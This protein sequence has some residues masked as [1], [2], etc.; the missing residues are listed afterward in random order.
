MDDAENSPSQPSG[1][2]KVDEK[3]LHNLIFHLIHCVF[4]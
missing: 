2:K 1:L 4:L 3:I